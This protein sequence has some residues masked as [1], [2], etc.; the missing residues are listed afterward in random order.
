MAAGEGRRLRPLT[1][2]WPKPLLPIDGRP[3]IE[4]LLRELAAA[5]VERATV[6]TGHL[7][8]KLETFLRDGD[9]LGLS[10]TFARQPE[11]IGA[12]DAILRAAASPP[13]LVSAADTVYTPGSVGHFV[14]A[15]KARGDGAAG[16]M[17]IRR[18]SSPDG[19]HT[20]IDVQDGRLVRVVS[21]QGEGPFRAAPLSIIGRPVHERLHHVV[22]PPYR[23][24]YDLAQAFQLAID[25]GKTVLAVEIGPTRDLTHPEDVVIQNFPY[26]E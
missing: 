14:S 4:T 6:V 11:A 1:E 23:Q 24:P 8:G 13:Y 18:P 2:R 22:Q 19:H 9:G 20:R 15:W 10:V 21:A 7:A 12:P 16:A 5:G 26:L 25:A 17:A 3:V